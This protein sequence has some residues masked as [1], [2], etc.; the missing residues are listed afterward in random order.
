V[1]SQGHNGD[2]VR[3]RRGPHAHTT[4][5]QIRVVAILQGGHDGKQAHLLMRS[6]TLRQWHSDL[7]ALFYLGARALERPMHGIMEHARGWCK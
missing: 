7:L 2:R 4:C 6:R 5:M 1:R 3:H